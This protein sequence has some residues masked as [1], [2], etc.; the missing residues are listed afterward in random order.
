MYST[1]SRELTIEGQNLPPQKA[2]LAYGFCPAENSQCP[3]DSGRNFDLPP[4]W[5][6]NLDRRPVPRTEL[7]LV[8]C[9]EYGYVWSGNRAWGRVHAVSHF[10]CLAQQ[11]FTHQTF[12]F[13]SSCKLPFL[14]LKSQAPTTISSFVFSCRWNLKDPCIHV[15]KLLFNFLLLTWFLSI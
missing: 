4:S 8:I 9:K 14:P 5:L 7:S 2:S 11:M 13:P 3:K 12:V 6:K 1:V 15:I 10:L